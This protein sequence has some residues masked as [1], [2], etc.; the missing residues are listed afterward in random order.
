MAKHMRMHWRVIGVGIGVLLLCLAAYNYPHVY[1]VDDIHLS[2]SGGAPFRSRSE[3]AGHIRGVVRDAGVQ[4]ELRSLKTSE[5][6]CSAVDRSFGLVP[7]GF[8]DGQ[9]KNVRQMATLGVEPLHLLVTEL[10]SGI[11]PVSLDVLRGLRV[12]LGEY[13][14]QR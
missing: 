11:G 9:F 5:E 13:G 2:W 3:M 4:L 14:H 1:W 12:Q 8:K 6:V 7:G 10:V